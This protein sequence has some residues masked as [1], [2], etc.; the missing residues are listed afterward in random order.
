MHKAILTLSL[1]LAALAAPAAIAAPM[2]GAEAAKQLFPG[3]GAEVRLMQVKG[4]SAKDGRVLKQVGASQKYY[5]AIAI[6]PGDGL[7]NA[8]TVAAADFHSTEPAE[9]AALAACN[10]R[11]TAK[12][13][14]VIA[15]LI[16]PKGYRAGRSLGLSSQATEAFESTYMKAAAPKAMAAS[17]STG[18]YGIAKGRDAA[19]KAVQACRAKA[20]KG[21][22]LR[23]CAVVIEN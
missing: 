19:R 4:L 16:E 3:A 8:A 18:L 20:P 13:P 11:K 10:A 17:P 14:C 1:T 2:T 9:R 5:G 6:S 7:V 22:S 23:D 15:A 21:H 12:T